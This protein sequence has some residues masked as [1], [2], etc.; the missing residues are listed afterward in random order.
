M[1]RNRGGDSISEQNPGTHCQNPLSR[2]EG[3]KKKDWPIR[4]RCEEF[5]PLSLERGRNLV[6]SPLRG[7]EKDHKLSL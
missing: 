4:G 2:K 5:V 6:A 7:R 1:L 3:A